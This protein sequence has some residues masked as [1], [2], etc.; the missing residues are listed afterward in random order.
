MSS[1]PGLWIAANGVG[2]AFATPRRL[3][4]P[5]DL[6]GRVVVLD[7]AFASESGGSR[8]AFEQSTLPF[9]EALG[10][11]LAAWVDHHDS[12]HHRRF[13][14]DPRFVLATK[15][16]HGACP[17]M[18][19]VA[20]VERTG[21]IDT[22][23][24]HTDFDGL[25]SAAKWVLGGQ[26]PYPGCDDDARAI[27]TR[28]GHPSGTGLLFDRALRA[29]PRD[30][31]LLH[32]MLTL[33]ASGLATGD[34]EAIEA[35]ANEIAPL[36]E[37]AGRLAHHYE[38]ASHDLVLLDLDRVPASRPYDKTMLLLRGQE[39]SKMAAVIDGD[40][41][42]FAAAYDSGID[43]TARFGL[44]G[45]MPTM[46]SIHRVHLAEALRSL[47]ADETFVSRYAVPPAAPTPTTTT[48]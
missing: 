25:A 37:E 7:I 13:E 1:R 33:L 15:A 34:W 30:T 2:I 28:K 3:P 18:V 11:R 9:I 31:G 19:T 23:V 20:L 6:P 32:A 22:L 27:D 8:N 40:T 47:G 4:K 24:C 5:K 38:H 36:E 42:T 12:V 17:E 44:S 48:S 45:G 10:P 35:A 41:A 16:Q 39:Q 26:E 43:F 29:R 14:A 21:P 46:V